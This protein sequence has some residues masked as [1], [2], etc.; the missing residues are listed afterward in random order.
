M[1]ESAQL[2]NGRTSSGGRTSLNTAAWEHCCPCRAPEPVGTR[3]A[4]LL[5][6]QLQSVCVTFCSSDQTEIFVPHQV[7]YTVRFF[8]LKD[9][10]KGTRRV[11]G[12][13][14]SLVKRIQTFPWNQDMGWKQ[15]ELLALHLQQVSAYSFNTVWVGCNHAV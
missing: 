3:L 2:C 13:L 9:D 6:N 7:F 12:H 15:Q 11:S 10:R 5:H 1:Q 8:I 4:L 14:C